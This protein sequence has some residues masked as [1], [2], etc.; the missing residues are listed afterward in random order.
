M[1]KLPNEV[2]FD[3]T[4]HLSLKDK[5]NLACAS[6]QLYTTISENTL[7]NKLVIKGRLKFVKALDLHAKKNFGHQ[8]HHLCIGEMYHDEKLISPLPTVFSRVQFLKFN[9]GCNT[10]YNI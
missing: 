6:K 3:I 4:S 5:L 2:V 8:V 7:Y 10:D 9:G 1:N